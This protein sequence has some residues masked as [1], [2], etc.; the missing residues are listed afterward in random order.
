MPR[1]MRASIAIWLPFV[2]GTAAI[3]AASNA[4]GA[5]PA[6]APAPVAASAA[7]TAPAE[8]SGPTANSRASAGAEQPQLEEVVVTGL[9]ASLEK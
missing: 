3:A 1:L 6:D 7:T 9:K 4:D 8:A 5:A 2:T